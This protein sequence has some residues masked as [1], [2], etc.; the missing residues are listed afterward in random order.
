MR[1][2]WLRG[3]LQSVCARSFQPEEANVAESGPLGF[4]DFPAGTCSE[5]KLLGVSQARERF[6]E[7]P[8][9]NLEAQ[10]CVLLALCYLWP[11]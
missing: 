11:Q 5:M 6:S 7:K 1:R 4:G 10:E 3:N 8:E 9:K 2:R